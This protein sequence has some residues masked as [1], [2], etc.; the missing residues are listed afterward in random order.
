MRRPLAAAPAI[1]MA[2]A[3]LIAGCTGRGAAG[4]AGSTPTPAASGIGAA[5]GP[6]GPAPTT[7]AGY[8]A[9]KLRWRSCGK[10][11]QCARLLVPFD[12]RRPAW[13]RF[14]LPVI[15][16]P[17]SDPAHRI[18][19]LVINPGGPGGSGIQYARQAR[20]VVSAA[21]RA[22]FDVV[23]FDP[24]G[25]GGSTPAIH[26]LTGPQLDKYFATTDNP[27]SQ[28]QLATVM[29][30]AKLFARECERRSGALL[31]YVGTPSAA[32]STSMSRAALGVPT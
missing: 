20:Q 8:Y 1:V 11:F 9:Q 13:R 2:G 30:E 23:G 10:G 26:C 31:P 27:A 15:R 12:Y 5:V 22:R 16:L 29:S 18:G 25:V 17:A 24:R 7:I 14:S 4:P 6:A 32:R 28:A 21:V 19:S 3:L